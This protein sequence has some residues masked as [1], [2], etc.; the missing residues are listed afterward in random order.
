MNRR[1]GEPFAELDELA[2]LVDNTPDG[3]EQAFRQLISR[4]EQ[5]RTLGETARSRAEKLF[6]AISS[7]AAYVEIYRSLL[8]R[9]TL[10]SASQ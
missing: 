5:R 7:E 2:M 1:E 9:A 10:T 6:G 3:Y 4:E 8:S